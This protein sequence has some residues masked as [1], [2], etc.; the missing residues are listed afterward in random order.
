MGMFHDPVELYMVADSPLNFQDFDR[1][2]YRELQTEVGN[3]FKTI[4]KS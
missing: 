2:D 4:K 1:L 3:V